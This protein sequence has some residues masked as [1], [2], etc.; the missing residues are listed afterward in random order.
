MNCVLDLFIFFT[1]P[2]PNPNQTCK[3]RSV[4]EE[5][6][7]GGGAFLLPARTYLFRGK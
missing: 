1:N 5:G 6:G 7:G 2:C 4:G 3:S